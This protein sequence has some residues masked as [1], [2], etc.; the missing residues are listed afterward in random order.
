MLKVIDPARLKDADAWAVSINAAYSRTVESIIAVG[1]E[2][3]DAKAALNHGA[4]EKMV[5][6]KLTFGE[7]TA[8]RLMSI[9]ACERLCAPDNRHL[10]PSSISSLYELS[11]IEPDVWNSMLQHRAIK[12]EATASE[13]VCLR[14][15]HKARIRGERQPAPPQQPKAPI[16][17]FPGSE[18]KPPPT[19]E[20]IQ[21]P[22]PAPAI[23]GEYMPAERKPT[24]PPPVKQGVTIEAKTDSES[25]GPAFTDRPYRDKDQLLRAAK[26]MFDRIYRGEPVGRDE[27]WA[28]LSGYDLMKMGQ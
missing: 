10:L 16:L 18:Q 11:R 24:T 4:F 17:A 2:L 23:S 7:R 13:L 3:I 1:R 21:R 15:I 12:P 5:R 26:K 20:I 9:A 25:S 22:A 19:T 27:A 8:Q 14:D 28:W 6:T